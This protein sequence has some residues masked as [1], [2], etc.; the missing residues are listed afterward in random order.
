MTLTGYSDLLT[1]RPD[2]TIAFLFSRLGTEIA[3]RASRKGTT[4]DQYDLGTELG[5]RLIHASA[6]A[7]V[8]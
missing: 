5:V 7:A 4:V 6:N 1:V 3:I 8:S 2:G